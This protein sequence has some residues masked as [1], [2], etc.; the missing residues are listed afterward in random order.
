MRRITSVFLAGPD[1][2]Y[3]EG[4][5]LIAAKKAACETAGFIGV[6]GG[7]GRPSRAASDEA[8]ARGAYAD[9]LIQ[10]R[11]CEALIANLTPWRGPGCDP[12]T[13]FEV[14]FAAA[15]GMPVFAY[16][17]VLQEDEAE[18]RGRVEAYMGAELDRLGRWRDPDGCEIEDFGLAESLMLWA[19]ARRLVVIV[20]PDPLDDLTGV[21]VC[22]EALALYAD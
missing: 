18:Y 22:L 15:L 20:T 17:N 16:L 21:E 7:E 8:D 14:G 1:L 6:A 19:E 9:T 13:A 2:F 10:L 5:A 4:Q 12:G 11:S 3:P